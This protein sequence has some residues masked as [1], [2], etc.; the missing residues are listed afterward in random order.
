MQLKTEKEDSLMKKQP[1]LAACLILLFAGAAVPQGSRPVSDA[2]AVIHPA[3]GSTC[4]GI[5]RFTQLSEGVRIVADLEGL[6]PNSKHGFHIHQ[7]GDCSA[8]DATSA[9]GHFD[10]AGTGHH[11]GP[12]DAVRHAGDMGNVDADANGKVHHEL[13]LDGITVDGAHAPI[14]GLGVIVH[15]KADDFGQPV[16]NAGGRIGCGVIGVAKPVK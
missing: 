11:G 16:G 7:Y 8:P 9:G 4:Q 2:V 3:S 12:T 14:L 13:V 6:A 15:A 5:V 10:P 1:F